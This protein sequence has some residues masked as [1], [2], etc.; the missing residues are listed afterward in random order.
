MSI[1]PEWRPEMSVGGATLGLMVAPH[2]VP[3]PP[4]VVPAT[5]KAIRAALL[6]EE[7]SDFDKEYRK[8]MRAAMESLDLTELIQML[9]RWQIVAW[10]TQDDPE[11]HRTMLDHMARINR[12]ERIDTVPW[13]T[14]KT[15][16]GL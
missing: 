5:P 1:R 4:Q 9:G 3:D 13:L 16:L 14:F 12:G 11:A 2:Q 8:V 15:R 10:S 7:R 6:P